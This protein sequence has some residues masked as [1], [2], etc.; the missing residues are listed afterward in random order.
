M[1][2]PSTLF[3]VFGVAGLVKGF[4]DASSPVKS[5]FA[6]QWKDEVLN[7]E[8]TRF[9]ANHSQFDVESTNGGILCSLVW[10]LPKVSFR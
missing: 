8:V 6:H 9:C 3:L 1:L 7:S 2:H 10:A 4:Y 5:L